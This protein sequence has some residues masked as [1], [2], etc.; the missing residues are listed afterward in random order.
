MTA[1]LH[2]LLV[3]IKTRLSTALLGDV[4]DAMGATHQFLPP[5]LRPLNPAHVL[6]GFAMTVLEADCASDAG[7]AAADA[8]AF[9]LMF[10]ALDD[11]APDEIYICTGGSPR[12]AL[13]GELMTARARELK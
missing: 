5:G 8:A 7:G 10:K 4:L 13:W 12:Y 6:A 1:Q 3:P 9:G 11:L 2:D